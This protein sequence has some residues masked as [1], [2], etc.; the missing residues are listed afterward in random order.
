M[1]YIGLVRELLVL[2]LIFFRDDGFLLSV[3]GLLACEDLTASFRCLR[4]IVSL[5]FFF[6]FPFTWWTVKSEG[7]LVFSLR[8][9][10]GL[11]LAVS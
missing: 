11:P 9:P 5:N 8:E 1:Y 4:S 6:F 3:I 7:N 10:P 2:F